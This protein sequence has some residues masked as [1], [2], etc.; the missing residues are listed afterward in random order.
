MAPE[1]PDGDQ[2]TAELGAYGARYRD[3]AGKPDALIGALRGDPDFAVAFARADCVVYLRKW[4]T[5]R[6]GWAANAQSS[7][8]A[9]PSGVG[10]E[11]SFEG[12]HDGDGAFNGLSPTGRPV[13]VRG[14]TLVGVEA[15]KVKLR[16][17]VDWAGLFAQLGLTLNWRVP[18][19]AGPVDAAR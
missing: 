5:P 15:G 13:V 18:V 19:P 14:V 8:A 6:G 12:V 1:P 16:R 3:L 17:Y 2:A 10:V 11:W 9:G 4:F 7:G